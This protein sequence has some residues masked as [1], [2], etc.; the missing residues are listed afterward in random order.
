[1]A[2][3]PIIFSKISHKACPFFTTNRRPNYVLNSILIEARSSIR[4][5]NMYGGGWPPID[6]RSMD[7]K[8][9]T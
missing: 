9:G 4:P 6:Y 1:M 7:L 3:L 5:P 2:Y 8:I